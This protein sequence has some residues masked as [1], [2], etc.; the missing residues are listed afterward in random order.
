[1]ASTRREQEFLVVGLGRFGSALALQ[2]MELGREVM[3]VD[4]DARI[5]Q[6]HATA[7]THVVQADATDLEAMRELGASEFGTAVVAIGTNVE[8]SIL[9]TAVLVDLAVRRIV[10]KAITAP[11]GRILE[12]VGAHRVVFPEGDK[13]REEAFRL[14][15]RDVIDTMQIEGGFLLVETTAPAHL[16]GKTLAEAHIRQRFG[17]TVVAVKHRGERATYATPDTVIGAGDILVVAGETRVVEEFVQL[18]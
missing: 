2:L 14:A 5:V 7:L 10:A 12:R 4:G 13:G 16:V 18:R 6:D 1:L 17:I 11:H 3:G 9:A 8:A 15:G